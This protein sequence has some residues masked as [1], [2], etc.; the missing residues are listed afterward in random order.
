MDIAKEIIGK[1][2]ITHEKKHLSTSETGSWVTQRVILG[3]SI[4][5][6]QICERYCMPSKHQTERCKLYDLTHA[7]KWETV[8]KIHLEPSHAR[9]FDNHARGKA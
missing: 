7:S 5:K 8:Q 4:I 1:P 3:S 6:I 9:Y 2:D